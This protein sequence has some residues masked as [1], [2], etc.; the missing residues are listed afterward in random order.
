MDKPLVLS[1]SKLVW[2]QDKIGMTSQLKR[3][4]CRAIGR[5][6]GDPQNLEIV[7][8]VL[9]VLARHATSKMGEQRNER[10]QALLILARKRVEQSEVND[11]AAMGM[12]TALRSQRDSL[13][14]R[15]AALA[16]RKI[17]AEARWAEVLRAREAGEEDTS[18]DDA[19]ARE[20][21]GA[22]KT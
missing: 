9:R 17:V 1:S 13:D 18:N 22:A 20:G 19:R 16:K 10:E 5:M 7:M 11:R 21:I 2:P 3:E 12:E 15:I 4:G 14:K 6:G 8:E